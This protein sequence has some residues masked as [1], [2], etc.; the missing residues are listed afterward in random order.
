MVLRGLRYSIKGVESSS[1]RMRWFGRNLRASALGVGSVWIKIVRRPMTA[2]T[3]GR[4]D[5]VVCRDGRD[6][7]AKGG[8]VEPTL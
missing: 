6:L 8:C 5:R 7:A 3:P 1:G 4:D 2:D